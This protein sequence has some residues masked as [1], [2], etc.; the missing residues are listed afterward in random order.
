M[1]AIFIVTFYV[2]ESPTLL[3]DHNFP[4]DVKPTLSSWATSFASC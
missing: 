1:R 3:N 4:Y 2:I